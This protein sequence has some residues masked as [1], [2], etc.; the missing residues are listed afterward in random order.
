[1]YAYYMYVKRATIDLKHYYIDRYM[2]HVCKN[3][4]KEGTGCLGHKKILVFPVK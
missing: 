1:M 3:E 4:L 2:H